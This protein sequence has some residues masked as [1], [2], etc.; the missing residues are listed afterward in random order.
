MTGLRRSVAYSALQSYVGV[1]LQLVSTVVLSR[2][3]TPAEVGVFV[4]A[5]VFSALASNFR[6]F[7]IAEYLI[8]ARDLTH[9]TIR[10]AFAVN[11]ALSWTMAALLFLAAPWV[12]EFYRA[13]G[14]RQVM[15]VQALG[16]LMI[17]FGAINQAWYRR[18][19]TFKP[20]FVASVASDSLSLLLSIVLAL[21]GFGALSMAWSTVAGIAITVLISM[22]YRPKDFPRWPGLKGVR[23]V[24]HFGG[25]A[26]TI[27]VLGQLG[28]SAPEMVIG[29]A[30][31][32]TEVAIFSRGAGLVQLFRQLV[33]RAVMPVCLPYFAQCVREE[34][35]VNRAYVRGVAIFTAVG[36]TFLGYLAL[37][38]FGA[39]R[40]VYGSQWVDAVPLARVLCVA[41]AVEL[42]HQL[43]KEALLAHGLV[44]PASRLQLLQQGV[45]LAGLMAVLPFGLMGACWGLLAAAAVNLV[46]A[47]QHL[48]AAT[49]F[50]WAALWGALRGSL[51]VGGL[52]LAPA[53]LLQALL[54]MAEHNYLAHTA[55]GATLTALGWLLALRATGHPLWAE[56][57]RLGGPVLQ[58]LRL[59]R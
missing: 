22:A 49:G 31:G 26:S 8:Q 19:M 55:A 39:I 16:F 54:P 50:G 27:Y 53:A 36:F 1:A 2:I 10:A 9:D 48:R 42:V 25:F 20:L 37:S 47:Q 17:P 57:A 5:A 33:L 44:K 24:L 11:I 41:G 32:V 14:V 59:A 30:Q 4:V 3:L 13:D 46:L 12:G 35:S 6:D 18:Q 43:A 23:E 56:I 52:A 38:P 7:G 34:N 15:Q 40:L 28:R 58:R 29:R 51:V 45:Q 21:Q